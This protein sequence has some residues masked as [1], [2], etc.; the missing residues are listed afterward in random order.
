MVAVQEEDLFPLCLDCEQINCLY[1]WPELFPGHSSLLYLDLTCSAIIFN[2]D[3]VVTA[4]TEQ[5]LG[6]GERGRGLGCFTLIF[7]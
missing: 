6:A 4:G 7:F 3:F 2:K 5:F 1:W